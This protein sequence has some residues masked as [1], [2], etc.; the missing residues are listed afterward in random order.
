MLV[1]LAGCEEP[2]STAAQGI[3]RCTSTIDSQ[4]EN[5]TRKTLHHEQIFFLG[6]AALF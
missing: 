2:S 5:K 3:A 4:S 6:V 1:W